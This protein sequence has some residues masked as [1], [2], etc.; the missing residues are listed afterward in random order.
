VRDIEALHQK[1]SGH[2]LQGDVDS[3]LA[4]WR[5]L[6]CVDPA[7]ER[8]LEGVRLCEQLV[9][10]EVTSVATA[11]RSPF[12]VDAQPARN[13]LAD[14]L[15]DLDLKLEFQDGASSPP[16]SPAEDAEL[17]TGEL[18]DLSQLNDEFGDAEESPAGPDSS[19]TEP[20]V[21]HWDAELE[22]D[23][24][25][26]PSRSKAAAPSLVS[27]DPLPDPPADAAEPAAAV[28]LRRRV[29]E[30]LASALVAMESGRQD[31]ALRILDRI[32]ILDDENEAAQSLRQSLQA[33]AP[34]AGEAAPAGPTLHHEPISLPAADAA[35][36]L[37][38]RRA[39]AAD[40]RP[41]ASPARAAAPAP[42][43]AAGR[44]A[45]RAADKTGPPTAPRAAATR[46]RRMQW[47]ILGGSVLALGIAAWSLWGLLTGR[48]GG[49]A[50]I[51][52][53]AGEPV[54]VASPADVTTGPSS[55]RPSAGPRAAA[56]GREPTAAERLAAIVARGDAAFQAGDHR[57][58]ILA[59]DEALELRPGEPG[60]E[61]RLHAA[62]ERYR[63]Q[64]EIDE[65]WAQAREAFGAGDYK[66]ALRL[67]YRLP[68]E[69]G[70]RMERYKLN[71][72]FNLGVNALKAGDCHGAADHFRDAAEI[73]PQDPGVIEGRS[74][75]ALCRT[76]RSPAF[77]RRVGGLELRALED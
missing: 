73:G 64:K 13:A 23:G 62:G 39:P 37:E 6:L 25:P 36:P 32:L 9:G 15:D 67:F 14:A 12:A 44:A 50:E 22:A 8:A 66:T 34:A 53:P 49:G 57:A 68:G 28:E 38:V 20:A 29:N 17:E 46:S 30:L 5:E 24:P 42:T 43:P 33:Q 55:G 7:D 40:E 58:A 65:Q 16:A 70:G 72:W 48:A 74:L 41:P 1:A 76:E 31:E 19:K 18:L 60:L 61:E 63:E 51:A 21:W 77:L 71:G 11:G 75:A 10:S 56:G 52:T 4:A 47:A 45:R 26:A 27:H 69:A 59:Y 2:Y 35:V 54:A 3:A